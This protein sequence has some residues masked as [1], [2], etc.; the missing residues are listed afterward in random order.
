M[1]SS[2]ELAN[3]LI[4][5]EIAFQRVLGDPAIA[6]HTGASNVF[7]LRVR[8]KDA[9]GRGSTEARTNSEYRGARFDRGSNY[10]NRLAAAQA[11]PRFKLWLECGKPTWAE[12]HRGLS[13]DAKEELKRQGKRARDREANIMAGELGGAVQRRRS[14]DASAKWGRRAEEWARLHGLCAE[15]V[16]QIME[17]DAKKRKSND[18]DSKLIKT[19]SGEDGDEPGEK[20]RDRDRAGIERMQRVL[21]LQAGAKG[22]AVLPLFPIFRQFF[23]FHENPSSSVI[24]GTFSR[25]NRFPQKR[26]KRPKIAKHTKHEP[27]PKR[28]AIFATFP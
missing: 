7:M 18:D 10:T 25:E 2:Q 19:Y 23:H 6:A 28:D 15:G 22:I 16:K 17:Y 4:L 11:A 27:L 5:G 21:Q 26:Q 13:D 3:S 8:V 20:D 24:S 12:F 9:R 14:I 1:E